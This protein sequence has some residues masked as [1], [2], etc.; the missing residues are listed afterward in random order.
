MAKRAITIWHVSPQHQHCFSNRL[1]HLLL[2]SFPKIE[3]H[4]ISIHGL[5]FTTVVFPNTIEEYET[6]FA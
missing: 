1:E 6:A 2:L 5:R 3:S 4:Q